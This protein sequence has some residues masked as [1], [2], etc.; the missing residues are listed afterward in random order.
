MTTRGSPV[1]SASRVA[2]TPP[3]TEFS[4]GTMA[5]SIS[6]A[7]RASSAASTLPN[8]TCSLCL[9]PSHASSAICVKVPRG[10]R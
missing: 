6:V 2:E 8:G 9:A 10:P 1:A 3:S 7:R 5:A 4:M